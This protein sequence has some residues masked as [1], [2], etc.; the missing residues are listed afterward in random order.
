VLDASTY[1]Q[2]IGNERTKAQ[3]GITSWY[4]DYPHPLDW[5]AVL[6]NGERITPT[7]NNS[8]TTSTTTTSRM[9][10]C[11]RSTRRSTS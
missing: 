8:T 6:L 5:F 7:H 3:I 11:R 2:A 1:F 10:T 4:E 9:P